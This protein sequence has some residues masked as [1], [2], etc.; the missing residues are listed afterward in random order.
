MKLCQ[1]PAAMAPEKAHSACTSATLW[2]RKLKLKAKFESRSSHF[3]FKRLDP[4]GLNVG[5]MESTCTALP[6]P[7]A[8]RRACPRT[9]ATG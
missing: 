6:R 2:R 9:A 4:G 8:P 1:N 3:S 5:L 7:A